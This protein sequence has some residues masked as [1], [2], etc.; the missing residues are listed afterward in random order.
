MAKKKQ[1]KQQKQGQSISDL[2]FNG[3]QAFRKGDYTRAIFIWEQMREK[4]PETSPINALA[5]TYFRRGLKSPQSSLD[6]LQKAAT[7]RP[8]EIRY[9]YYLGRGYYATGQYPQAVTILEKVSQSTPDFSYRAAYLLALSLLRQGKNPMAHPSWQKLPPAD[10]ERIEHSQRLQQKPPMLPAGATPVLQALAALSKNQLDQA[11]QHLQQAL[12]TEGIKQSGFIYYLLGLVAIQQ[13]KETLALERWQ[14]A[15]N[16]GLSNP[17]LR[18]NLSELCHRLAEEKLKNNDYQAAIALADRGITYKPENNGLTD[19]L[20]HAYQIVAFEAANRN[21]W[22]TA[23]QFLELADSK[24]N[25]SFRLAYNLALV[26]EKVEMFDSAADRWREALRRRPRR[27]DH[28]DAMSDEEISRI[29]QRAA[30]AYMREEE[31]EEANHV[32]KQAVKWQPDN[33]NLRMALINNLD[34][35]GRF[36]AAINEAERILEQHPNYVPALLRLGELVYETEPSWSVGRASTYWEKA[37]ELEPSNSKAKQLLAEFYEE[38]ATGLL[39]YEQALF[40]VN[41]ALSYNPQKTALLTKKGHILLYLKQPNEAETVFAEAIRVLPADETVYQVIVLAYSEFNQLDRAFQVIEQAKKNL[42]TFDYEFFFPLISD[43]FRLGVDMAQQWINK[44]IEYAPAGTPIFVPI[45]Q[46]CLTHPKGAT[47]AKEYL[48]KA[49][50]VGEYPGQTYLLL[51]MLASQS[52]DKKLADKH[53]Q[54]A[55]KIARQ[56][57]DMELQTRIQQIEM[58]FS[59]PIGLMNRLVGGQLGTRDV[60]YFMNLINQLEDDNDF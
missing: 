53:W 28:P 47:L 43:S 34:N 48:A 10:R 42:P 32:Y 17:K 45:A 5:E 54:Q 57:K 29:W 20:S 27:S 12:A 51:G 24:T 15:F 31:F 18:D 35:T 46:L 37:L 13:D 22:K 59:G 4:N 26:Y 49:L 38:K 9:Q 2:R 25:G 39:T 36:Q 40:Y 60:E 1:Q 21:D 7:L 56:T 19:L 41:K 3:L 50:A 55:K 30:E 11:E 52:G 58:I 16:N 14:K 23:S 8:T 33:L 44:V 6:D